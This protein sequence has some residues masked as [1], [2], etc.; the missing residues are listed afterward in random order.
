[1]KYAMAYKSF[2]DA[3]VHASTGS[4][5]G[6][7]GPFAPLMSMQGMITRKGFNGETWGAMQKL[8]VDQAIR[9]ASANGAYNTR[10][11][12][13]KGTITAGKLADY[14]V[15]ADDL[16]KIDPEKIKDVKIVQTVVG[17]I[18]RYQA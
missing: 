5:F 15:L 17:G 7:P 16:H 4:D 9:A 18:T 3:G 14:V 6:T 12:A 11:E 13:I 10:E 8:T 2:E 1:M